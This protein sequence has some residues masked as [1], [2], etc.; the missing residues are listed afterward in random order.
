[1]RY[2]PEDVENAIDLKA[3]WAEFDGAFEDLYFYDNL[4][5]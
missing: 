4:Y 3:I 2:M 5:L 1:M